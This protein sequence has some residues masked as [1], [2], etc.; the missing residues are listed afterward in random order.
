[1][2]YDAATEARMYVKGNWWYDAESYEYV[3]I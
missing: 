1:L 3:L 2:H